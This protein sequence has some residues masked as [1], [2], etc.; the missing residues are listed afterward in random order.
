MRKIKVR[1]NPKMGRRFA[2]KNLY[3][4]WLFAEVAKETAT[5]PKF[6]RSSKCA[7]PTSHRRV[8]TYNRLLDEVFG[9]TCNMC[10]WTGRLELAHLFYADDSVPANEHNGRGNLYRKKEALEHPERFFRLCSVC[11]GFFDHAR[12]NGGVSFLQK[13]EGLMNLAKE[14]ESCQ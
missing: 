3:H 13:L 1:H 8:E 2:D 5:F 6:K 7:L 12:R 10:G 14:L 11:H 4:E 9:N